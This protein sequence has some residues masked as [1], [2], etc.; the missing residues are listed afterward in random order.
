MAEKIR[1]TFEKTHVPIS[2]DQTIPVTISIGVV[3]EVPEERD[4]H[5]NLLRLAD[6]LLYQAKE[7]GRNRVE[8]HKAGNNPGFD[9][10]QEA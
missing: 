7:N 10:P 5:E 2:N 1:K 8:H 9:Q 3:S 6:D 4:R